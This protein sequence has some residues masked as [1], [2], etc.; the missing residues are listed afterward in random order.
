MH[1][2]RGQL[3]HGHPAPAWPLRPGCTRVCGP[4]PAWRVGVLL[5]AGTS[6]QKLALCFKKVTFPGPACGAL[7]V[8]WACCAL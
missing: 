7:P 8:Q 5:G 3:R 1:L 6:R 2:V 4:A